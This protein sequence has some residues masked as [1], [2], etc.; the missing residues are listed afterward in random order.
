MRPTMPRSSRPSSAQQRRMAAE[1]SAKRRAK[2]H[3]EQTA[4]DSNKYTSPMLREQGWHNTGRLQKK[5]D[6]V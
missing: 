1:E 2:V 5:L 6:I 3:A 4:R